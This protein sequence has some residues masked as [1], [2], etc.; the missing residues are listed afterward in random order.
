M[1][2]VHPPH[3]PTH[4]WKDF[5]IHVATICV[6]LLIAVGLE[7]AVE[8]LVHRHER[9]ELIENMRAQAERNLPILQNDV[10]SASNQLVW[11]QS[12][13]DLLTQTPVV[14]GEIS[15]HLPAL[16][17]SPPVRE[18]SRAVWLIARAKGTAALLPED[19]AEVYD[20]LDYDAQNTDEA[21][22]AS[23]STEGVAEAL[24]ARFHVSLSPG[25]SVRLSAAQR[26]QTTVALSNVYAALQRVRGVSQQWAASS[27]AVL[28]H[29]RTRAEMNSY[30]AHASSY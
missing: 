11:L 21:V 2:D 9:A 16:P 29:V 6:G 3:A 26:D 17:P 23:V 12:V 28:H 8:A 10:S 27:D 14:A 25:S 1:L 20:R 24:E 18:P 7:Q 13:L 5:F 15:V 30:L 19:L 4:T 22:N